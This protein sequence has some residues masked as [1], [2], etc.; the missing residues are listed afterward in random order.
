MRILKDFGTII[1]SCI[2]IIVSI[3]TLYVSKLQP[4]NIFF[5]PSEEVTIWRDVGIPRTISFPI[6]FQN[7]G[8]SLGIVQKVALLINGPKKQ[9]PYIVE[10]AGYTELGVSSFKYG[11]IAIPG[12]SSVINV[13]NFRDITD[14][15]EEGEGIYEVEI[16][17]W[18][19]SSDLPIVKESFSI[20]L[21]EGDIIIFK[22]TWQSRK[23]NIS[24]WL[25]WKPGY[26]TDPKILSYL[27]NISNTADSS[28]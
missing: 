5:F 6:T 15:L 19:G 16:L 27:S 9:T 1:L 11:P 23:Y 25:N 12:N 21:V 3:S 4:A 14:M 2:A 28:Q 13:F 17:S 7:S 8:A 18:E 26:V 20:D 10:S 22:S 24:K